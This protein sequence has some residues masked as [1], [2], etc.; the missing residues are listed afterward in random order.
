[1]CP[2]RRVERARERERWRKREG[3]RERENEEEG[4]RETE[5]EREKEGDRERVGGGKERERRGRRKRSCARQRIASRTRILPRSSLNSGLFWM[6]ALLMTCARARARTYARNAI[7]TLADNRVGECCPPC[8]NPQ[9]TGTGIFASRLA[10]RVFHQQNRAEIV[11]NEGK[12]WRTPRGGEYQTRCWSGRERGTRWEEF[13]IEA[14]VDAR[15]FR[16]I[17]HG[18]LIERATT[19]DKW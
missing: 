2:E 17:C 18:W 14:R 16:E 10:Q 11:R 5:G 19:D 13:I 7:F 3:K 4:E 8:V 6:S 12:G 1:M 9:I 15:A